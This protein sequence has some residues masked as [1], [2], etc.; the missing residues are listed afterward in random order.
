MMGR[1]LD[2]QRI[3]ATL[4]LLPQA[5]VTV[6]A[7]FNLIGDIGLL[8]WTGKRNLNILTGFIILSGGI[9]TCMALAKPGKFSALGPMARLRMAAAGWNFLNG[10]WLAWLF[11]R[12]GSD[13]I[14]LGLE[15]ALA[16]L[17]LAALLVIGGGPKKQ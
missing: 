13:S 1:R 8:D 10:V 3:I 4:L 11:L 16:F 14:E 17:T 15:M 5:L 6:L 9:V 2:W 12:K 7:L